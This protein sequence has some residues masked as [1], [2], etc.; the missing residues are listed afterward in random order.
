MFTLQLLPQKCIVDK[1]IQ[2]ISYQNL[3]LQ[4]NVWKYFLLLF[5]ERETSYLYL[6]FRE[7][8]RSYIEDQY[9]VLNFFRKKN[10]HIY[11]IHDELKDDETE[12]Y[13]PRLLLDERSEHRFAYI[14]WQIRTNRLWFNILM[15]FAFLPS[16]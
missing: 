9:C 15:L 12:F 13:Y 10:S 3:N 7:E 1:I 4:F 8:I 14:S 16:E 6:L 5:W 2:K 11:M